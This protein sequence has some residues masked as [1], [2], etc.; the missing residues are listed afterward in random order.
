MNRY[1]FFSADELRCR[2]GCGLGQDNM[3]PKFM[4][5]LIVLR[6][7]TGIVM[8]VTSA[9]RCWMHN[10]AVSNTGPSGPHVPVCLALIDGPLCHAVDVRIAGQDAYRLIEAAFDLRLGFTGIGISQS[11]PMKK[12]FLHFDDLPVLAGCPRPRVWSY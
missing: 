3:D 4:G 12:R 11:G 6:R 7:E 10:Q 9:A 8:P 1:E 2:C 5:K